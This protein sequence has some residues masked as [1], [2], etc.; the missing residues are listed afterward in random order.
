MSEFNAMM[1][2]DLDG[3]L[4]AN[5]KSVSETN[6][7]VF[8]LLKEKRIARV[9]ATGRSLYGVHSVLP[10]DF[11]IDYLIFSSGAGIMHWPDKKVLKSHTVGQPDIHKVADYFIKADLDFFIHY[12]I[13]DTHYCYCFTSSNPTKDHLD[14]LKI[15]KDFVCKNDFKELEEATQLL[16]ITDKSE[17]YL[18]ELRQNFGHL[19]IIR[20]T[21][22]I[23]KKIVWIEVFHPEAD[24]G[25]ATRWLS[26]Y[27]HI[28]RNSTMSVG[29]DYNDLK[30]L[31]WTRHAYILENALPELKNKFNPA[32][33]NNCDG[34]HYAVS[35]WLG[36]IG[37]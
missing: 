14:R 19:N 32:P 1:L 25:H 15:Y 13:P 22:P 4:L 24:K 7:R 36:R 6:L 28:D 30:M 9:A 34:F 12:P 18:P 2:T 23:D 37:K 29:N 11:P 3:T 21:S 5:D 27:L 8:P 16:A 26:E 31:E 20:T 35:D 33:A 10:D 17:N